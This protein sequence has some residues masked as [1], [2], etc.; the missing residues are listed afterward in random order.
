MPLWFFVQVHH[1]SCVVCNINVPFQ[2]FQIWF[3]QNLRA[4]AFRRSGWQEPF[5]KCLETAF[6]KQIV[7]ICQWRSQK[8]QHKSDHV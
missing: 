1:A 4:F 8:C 3:F 7:H 2:L 5:K 6:T